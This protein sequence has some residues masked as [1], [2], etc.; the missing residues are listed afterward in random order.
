[1]PPAAMNSGM[2]SV[3]AIEPKAVGYAV[4]KTVSTKISHTWLASH[5]GPIE[6]W[7]CSRMRSARGPSPATRSQKPAPKSAPP[8][9]V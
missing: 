4:Q 1:M 7:A 9:T 8:S 2:A 5:T 6:L 3:E